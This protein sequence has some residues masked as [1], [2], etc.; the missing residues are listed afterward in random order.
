[1]A[2]LFFDFPCTASCSDTASTQSK[3]KSAGAAEASESFESVAKKLLAIDDLDAQVEASA[4]AAG[5]AAAASTTEL[6]VTQAADGDGESSTWQDAEWAPASLAIDTR[7]QVSAD[8]AGDASSQS[9]AMAIPVDPLLS[10][11]WGKDDGVSPVVRDD[12]TLAHID[13]V[14]SADANAELETPAD[15][16]PVN[17]AESPDDAVSSDVE[18]PSVDQDDTTV[19][20]SAGNA[21][22]VAVAAGIPLDAGGNAGPNQPAEQ[23]R[24]PDDFVS[25]NTDSESAET[26]ARPLTGDRVEEEPVQAADGELPEKGLES[27]RAE[28]GGLADVAVPISGAS[29]GSWPQT[30]AVEDSVDAGG[31]SQ[32][33]GSLAGA[34]STEQVVAPSEAIHSGSDVADRFDNEIA[35]DER[36]GATDADSAVDDA[37]TADLAGQDTPQPL[38]P[39]SVSDSAVGA[40]D[41]NA[42]VSGAIQPVA[43]ESVADLE[44]PD[45]E[46]SGDLSVDPEALEPAPSDSGGQPELGG[47]Q[48]RR[49]D[50][51]DASISG[52]PNDVVPEA[53]EQPTILPID[54][55]FDAA[56]DV[57]ADQEILE[58]L[59]L[60]EFIAQS[61]ASP[62]AVKK[63]AEVI[64]DAMQASLQ[65]EGQTVR[66]EIHP[67][68]LGTLKIQVTQSDQSIETQ[69]IATEFVTSELLAGHRDQ[70]MEALS[71]LGFDSSE[72]NISFE[73]QSSTESEG[74][75]PPA[76]HRYQSKSETQSQVSRASVSGGGINIVA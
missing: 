47:Q 52:D 37:V 62:E 25:A 63:T 41:E 2:N 5:N 16:V 31:L 69:I 8:V 40:V 19:S 30:V 11:Q 57:S 4:V 68:E 65:L 48:S 49:D 17:E 22:V 76:E 20:D 13:S 44:S 39:G 12:A 56:S 59:S 60:E 51:F 43:K 53:N 42:A 45:V 9:D 32:S 58:T 64:K 61:P 26:G 29:E 55:S 27:V 28:S 21:E 73:D 72:V 54:A 75:Q 18:L 3:G 34:A 15:G 67:A 24:T 33:S 46:E 38:A 14:S 6:V 70:L 7:S 50:S 71:D 1:M 10:Q 23:S 36:G 35:S 74:R 66:V